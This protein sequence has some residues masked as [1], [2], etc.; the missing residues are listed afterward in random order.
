MKI[1]DEIRG[2]KLKMILT[3]ELQKYPYK[4]KLNYTNYYCTN[5]VKLNYTI[6]GGEFKL[7]ESFNLIKHYLLSI[8]PLQIFIN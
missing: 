3:E 2:E 4:V 5:I 1:D 8:K 6:L 7:N